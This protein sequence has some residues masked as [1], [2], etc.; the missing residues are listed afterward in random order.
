MKYKRR[1]LYFEQIQPYINDRLI[2]IITGQRRVGKSYVMNQIKDEILEQNSDANIIYINKE[3]Y[4]FDAIKN[5]V[6]LMYFLE[7][8]IKSKEKT[9][10]FIDEIQEIEEFEKAI[11][12]LQLTDQFDIYCT[13]SNASLLSGELATHLAGRYIQIR[14]HSLS[15][16]EYLDFHNC[17]DSTETFLEYLQFGGMPHLIN[18]RKS[19]EVYYEYLRNIYDSI[20]LRDVVAR[21][22]LR[23]VNTL[24]N[25]IQFLSDN[26]GSLFSATSISSFLKSQK[27]SLLPKTILEYTELLQLVYFIDGVKRAEI[28]GK[29]IFEIGEKFY[30]EDIG[31][32]NAIIPFQ[33][34]DLNKLLENIVYHHLKCMQFDVYIGQLGN[35]EVDF[36]ATKNDQKYYIQVA[37]LLIEDTTIER[38]FGNLEAIKDNYPKLVITMDDVPMSNSNGIEHWNIRKFLLNFGLKGFQ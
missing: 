18:L 31:M 24:Q 19:K 9:Y 17:E 6:D 2:K 12:S 34:Q 38:E 14:V 21:Y 35:K 25:L 23:N 8:T 27:I 32:R 4:A 10:L 30:F 20:I 1:P 37:Y 26:V 15:Y 13:G 7:P 33:I 36:I 5:Y 3:D 28:H 11:R 29:K 22:K 16:V